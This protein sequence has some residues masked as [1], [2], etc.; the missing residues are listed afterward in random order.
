MYGILDLNERNV[1][2][3]EIA[4]FTEGRPTK[5]A[6]VIPPVHV[7]RIE[8][9]P[10]PAEY[11]FLAIRYCEFSGWAE[12][13]ALILHLLRKFSFINQLNS[14]INRLSSL[15]PP[16]YHHGSRVWDTC[17][18]PSDMPFLGRATT[19]MAIECFLYPLKT[20]IHPHGIRTLI[21]NGPPQSGKSFTYN[22]ILYMNKVYAGL[23]FKCILIDYKK[24]ITARFGP[25]ELTEAI[26]D[27]IN[28]DWDKQ[29]VLPVLDTQQP[30]RW[31]LELAKVL[32]DQIL[33]NNLQTA[34][35][36]VRFL[37]LDG[38]NDSAVPR[39]TI[40]FIQVL[41]AIANGKE[42]QNVSEDILRLVLLGFQDVIP[43]FNN[44]LIKEDIEPL[45]KSDIETFFKRY[46]LY[47]N[48]SEEDIDQ[49]SIAA[50]V[51]K[52]DLEGIPDNQMRTRAIAEKVN[53]IAQTVF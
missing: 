16:L 38:F 47:K 39:E 13:P 30:A 6:T 46:G 5:L 33:A 9:H 32:I 17:L 42:Y 45:Q 34:A 11:A 7:S 1:L 29:I 50:M 22:Y 41:A 8:V 14:A 35:G 12:E 19:R 40:E 10:V 20:T 48:F 52:T 24:Q 31:M 4:L 2:I 43:N 36:T 53:K 51:D 3:P 27:Q 28:P 21:V 37:I 49:A 23:N 44:R 15:V 18:V 26:L 25:E